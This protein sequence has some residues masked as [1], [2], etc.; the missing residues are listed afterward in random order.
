MSILQTGESEPW[1]PPLPS[2]G[3]S[4]CFPLSSPPPLIGNPQPTMIAAC[5]FESFPRSYFPP[6]SSPPSPPWPGKNWPFPPL[7]LFFTSVLC[8][9]SFFFSFFSFF[10]WGS[11]F[12]PPLGS[13]TY[14]KISPSGFALSCPPC[15][16]KISFSRFGQFPAMPPLL[17][18]ALLSC[19]SPQNAHRSFPTSAVSFGTSRPSHRFSYFSGVGFFPSAFF[20]LGILFV[21]KRMSIYFSLSFPPTGTFWRNPNFPLMVPPKAPSKFLA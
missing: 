6:L 2:S 17:L 14:F 21:I 5:V 9:C 7:R 3:S 19:R 20:P 1:I 4:T 12:V 13:F 11:H 8:V 18:A 16:P 10:S 15:D